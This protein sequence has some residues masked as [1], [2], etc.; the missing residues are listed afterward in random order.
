MLCIIIIII[1]IDL[2]D[3]YSLSILMNCL[4]AFAKE[5]Q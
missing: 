4:T 1:I 5:I 2:V 3:G